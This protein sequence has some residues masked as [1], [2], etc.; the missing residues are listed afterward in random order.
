MVITVVISLTL[1]VQITSCH[2]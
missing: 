1:I 2:R